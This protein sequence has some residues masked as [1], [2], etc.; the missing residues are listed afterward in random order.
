MRKFGTLGLF[1]LALAMAGMAAGSAAAVDLKLG[2]TLPP[3][4]THHKALMTFADDVLKKS[5]G[6]LRIQVFPAEQL[7]NARDQIEALI[8][9]SQDMG[10]DGAGVMSQFFP[11]ISVLDMPFMFTQFDELR[12]VFESPVGQGLA[13]E[14]LE[15]RGLRLLAVS[16]YGARQVSSNKPIEKVE[17]FKGLKIRTPQV[18]E[19]VDSFKALDASPTPIAFGEVYFALQ[20]GVVDAQENPLST[21][22][23][24]KFYEVQKYIAMTNHQIGANYIIVNEKKWK[25][26]SPAHQKVLSEAAKSAMAAATA[27]VKKEDDA[28]V[29]T[30]EGKGLTFFYP[31]DATKA[32]IKSAVQKTY[33][34]Y[35]D[36][37]GKGTVDRIRE[38]LK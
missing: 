7:G 9:G 30:L 24:Y 28:L 2:H 25:S 23:A 32:A 1:G 37:W 6:E 35:D 8:R 13:R 36:K 22:D 17:D 14:L 27:D 34:N 19:W 4:H 38:V 11:K 31:D 18:K 15:K 20:T 10:Y 3:T 33:G 26:L 21:I 16:Y 5:N 29:K 12:K